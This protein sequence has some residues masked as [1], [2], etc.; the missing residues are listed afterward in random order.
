MGLNLNENLESKLS[1]TLLFTPPP[2]SMHKVFLH[3]IFYAI[4]MLVNHFLSFQ[5]KDKI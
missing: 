2:F 3:E 4:L 1:W 5:E